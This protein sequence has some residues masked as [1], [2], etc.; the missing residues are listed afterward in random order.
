[1]AAIEA[2]LAISGPADR[3]IAELAALLQQHGANLD[4]PLEALSARIAGLGKLGIG[5]ES[6]GF[7]P[8]FGRNIDYYTGFVFELWAPGPDGP[9]QVAGGGRYDTLMRTL[10]AETDIPA[11]GCAIRDERLLVACHV[12][13][14]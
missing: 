6:V 12:K 1:M 13:G 4:A 9:L 14:R 3:S 5:G 7:A 11:V 2:A 8:R 10:G